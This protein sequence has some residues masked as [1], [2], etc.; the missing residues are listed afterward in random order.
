MDGRIIIEGGGQQAAPAH[1]VLQMQP[2]QNIVV[3]NMRNNDRRD[4]I[5]ALIDIQGE[6]A[7]AS[8]F[9][10]RKIEV[11]SM[12]KNKKKVRVKQWVATTFQVF[13]QLDQDFKWNPRQFPS[14]TEKISFAFSKNLRFLLTAQKVESV[15]LVFCQVIDH[16]IKV[17]EKSNNFLNHLQSCVFD[18]NNAANQ[19]IYAFFDIADKFELRGY[20]HISK[21]DMWDFDSNQKFNAWL[22]QKVHC[23]EQLRY[24]VEY[25]QT[26]KI[27]VRIAK[28]WPSISSVRVFTR[29]NPPMEI[30]PGSL[31]FKKPNDNE[32]Q[33][34]YLS[35]E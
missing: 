26:F 3:Q 29:T 6:N 24:I 32:H 27:T 15:T 11:V 31:L 33:A 14:I 18:K 28:K 10:P 35:E 22:R 34:M 13:Q 4:R 5:N 1:P 23:L 17:A 7:A 2:I 21:P 16:E 25:C 30:V 12:T 8:N 9:Q 20:D 19:L